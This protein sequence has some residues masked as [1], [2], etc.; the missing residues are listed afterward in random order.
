MIKKYMDNKSIY[1]KVVKYCKYL[2]KLFQVVVKR[3]FSVISHDEFNYARI[4]QKDN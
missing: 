4:I 3:N 2:V 1:L